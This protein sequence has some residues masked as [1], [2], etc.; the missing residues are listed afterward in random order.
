MNVKNKKALLNSIQATFERPLNALPC[1]EC[2]KSL[3]AWTGDHF[4]S[5]SGSR[6][7]SREEGRER[8]RERR[9]EERKE[10]NCLYGDKQRA[11]TS[12][13]EF[14]LLSISGAGCSIFQPKS[15]SV[16]L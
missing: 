4:V 5:G 6:N 2:D 16:I 1:D 11:M 10:K 8:R 13:T 9:K 7:L 14:Q 15:I 3:R 12:F